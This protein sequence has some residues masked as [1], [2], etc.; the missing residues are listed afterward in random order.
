LTPATLGY[1]LSKS[2]SYSGGRLV[3]SRLSLGPSKGPMIFKFL[4]KRQSGNKICKK[5]GMVDGPDWAITPFKNSSITASK[6]I[7]GI[8]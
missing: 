2:I 4:I 3:F 8:P 1:C 6:S 5:E 7:S